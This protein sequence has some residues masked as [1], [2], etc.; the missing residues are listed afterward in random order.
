[1]PR[2]LIGTDAFKEVNTYGLSIPIAKHSYL[3]RSAAQ[4]LALLPE[5]FR[6]ACS[7][8]PGPVLIDVPKDVQTEALAV[9]RWP[10]AG[11]RDPLP[12]PDERALERAAALIE[13]AKRPLL[14]LGG[15]VI[16]S[17]AAPSAVAFAERISAPTVMTLMALGAM[18]AGHPLA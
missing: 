14:Y 13:Q 5:A 4:L 15:G 11:A 12:A 10:D 17:G 9:E 6:I 16:A 2:A 1:V 3:V 8:R 18:P 7:G